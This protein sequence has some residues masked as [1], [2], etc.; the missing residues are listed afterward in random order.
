MSARKFGLDPWASGLF[1]GQGNSN[2]EITTE[3]EARDANS[4]HSRT[5]HRISI[6]ALVGSGTR[7]HK[8]PG[9]PRKEDG[10]KTWKLVLFNFYIGVNPTLRQSAVSTLPF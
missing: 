2:L 10:S 7:S 9:S 4:F 3:H 8:H 6:T 5:A 1:A